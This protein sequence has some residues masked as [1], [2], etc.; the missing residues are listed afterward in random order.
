MPQAGKQAA[1]HGRP[2]RP[3][4]PTHP[5][6]PHPH[7]NHTH[8]PNAASYL[9]LP[10]CGY[11]SP[12]CT[13]GKDTA[14][15]DVT[16]VYD[17]RG[18][19]YSIAGRHEM[20]WRHEMASRGRENGTKARQG[21]APSGCAGG[22]APRLRVGRYDRGGGG[23]QKEGYVGGTLG[24]YKQ[25]G[26]S[27]QNGGRVLRGARARPA[28]ARPCRLG[29][30]GRGASGMAHTATGKGVCGVGGG[31]QKVPGVWKTQAC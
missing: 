23:G 21:E 27:S 20:R 13:F 16:A 14:R 1:A 17:D 7:T 4:N 2:P 30:A 12:A 8:T 5:P 15:C 24:V 26:T 18:G 6:H 10:R 31:T 22:H 3:P 11:C 19:E 29:W 9:V 28:S 25:E